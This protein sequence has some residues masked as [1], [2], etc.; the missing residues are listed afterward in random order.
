MT[1]HPV[2]VRQFGQQDYQACWQR[3]RAFTDAR[4]AETPDQIWLLEHTPV[5]T[6]GQNGKAEHVL[7]TGD[8]PLIQTDRGGQVTYH[9]PG[10]LVVYPLID[11][12]RRGLN[13]RATVT[14][15]ENSVIAL[16][17]EYQIY[18]IA[19]ADAPGVYVDEKKI[20]SIGLRVRRGCSYHGL[21]LNV[22]MDT[23][24]FTRINPCGFSGLQ[25]TQMADYAPMVE[26]R[27]VKLCL[28]SLLNIHLV[29][30]D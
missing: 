19:K 13:V 22:K 9:G 29:Q 2:I 25:M 14:W 6:Q 17:R 1:T 15:L 20:C 7:D 16:L 18:A 27:E 30:C 12:R 26:M 24:P 3:M 23:T 5:F 4:T 28:A 10:Q 11:L 8:I 21:A